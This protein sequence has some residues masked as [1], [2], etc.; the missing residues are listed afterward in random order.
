L[1]DNFDSLLSHLIRTQPSGFAVARARKRNVDQ[2]VL[3]IQ[4]IASS[5]ADP[6]RLDLSCMG[7]VG[8]E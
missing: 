2:Y 1:H 8:K 5:R 7:L 4:I 6:V 3:D